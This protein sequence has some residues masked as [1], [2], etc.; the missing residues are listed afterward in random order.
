MQRALRGRSLLALPRS[1]RDRS[2]SRIGSCAAPSNVGASHSA[3]PTIFRTRALR[4]KHP[5]FKR[6][7]GAQIATGS[8]SSSAGMI[9]PQPGGITATGPAH[10]QSGGMAI[11]SPPTGFNSHPNRSLAATGAFAQPC[12]RLRSPS[13]ALLPAASGGRCWGSQIFP[14]THPNPYYP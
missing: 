8:P 2:P 6:T 5:P 10:R 11:G 14:L 7:R 3:A 1:R 13:L 12:H 9:N 4:A